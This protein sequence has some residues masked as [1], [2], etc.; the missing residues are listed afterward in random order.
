MKFEEIIVAFI[1]LIMCLNVI[2]LTVSS[3]KGNVENLLNRPNTTCP[4]CY[5]RRGHSCKRK[6]GNIRI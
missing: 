5:V 1:G 4:L 2:C 6:S 3:N